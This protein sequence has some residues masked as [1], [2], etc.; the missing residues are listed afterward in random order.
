MIRNIQ[1]Q[2][3]PDLHPEH[4][5][6]T[7]DELASGKLDLSALDVKKHNVRIFDLMDPGQCEEY[8]KLYVDLAREVKTG[9]IYIAANT[10]ETL[11]RSDGST[12]WFRYVEW[13]E[14]DVSK[15]LGMQ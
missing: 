11:S 5:V 7:A 13:T 3:D 12:G 14:F 8:E 15:I 4:P 9:R 2:G 1:I 10:R 6:H